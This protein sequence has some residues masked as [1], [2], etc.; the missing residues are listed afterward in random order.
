MM[1]R[2]PNALFV[3]FSAS[4][5]TKGLGRIWS[6]L[7]TPTTTKELIKTI[8]PATG[9]SFLAPFKPFAADHPDLSGVKIVAGDYHEGQLSERMRS[10]KLTANAAET[11][12]TKARGRRCLV[13]CVDKA[14]AEAMLEMYCS[15]GILAEL[16]LGETPRQE[17]EAIFKRMEAKQTEVII[18]VGTLTTGVDLPFADALQLCRPTRSAMLFKQ[19]SGRVLRDFEGKQD[20]L[21]FD[22]SDNFRR[23]G[24]PD[25]IEWTELDDG[26]PNKSGKQEKK[27]AEPIEC[28]AC[29]ALVRPVQRSCPE[30]GHEFKRRSTVT[31]TKGELTE[32]KRTKAEKASLPE[33][34]QFYSMLLGYCQRHGRKPG[35]AYYKFREKFGVYPSGQLERIAIEPS[36]AVLS[37]IRSRNIAWANSQGRQPERRAA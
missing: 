14:H 3:G 11:Y 6:D 31:F 9:R 36:P 1:Q 32:V 10:T 28:V 5:G 35:W 25:E 4:P 15:M 2:W 27:P 8:N 33:K 30:C 34:Q 16:I 23:L 17:R 37:W 22:H 20:A 29:K 24:F 12:L 13:F 26:K 7:V 18:S 21:I 19:I